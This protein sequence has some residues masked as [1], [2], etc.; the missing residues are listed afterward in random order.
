MNVRITL[1]EKDLEEALSVGKQAIKMY[2]ANKTKIPIEQMASSVAFFQ[3]SDNEER[4]EPV[5]IIEASI[6]AEI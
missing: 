3:Q 6:N 2:I 4:I 5:S 1:I